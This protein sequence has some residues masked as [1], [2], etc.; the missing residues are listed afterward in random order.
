MKIF[1]LLDTQYNNF[2]EKA[3]NYLSK[4]LSNY[5]AN[6]GNSTIFGQ[7]INVLAGAIQ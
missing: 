4:T 3:K 7:L 2:I 6:Y 5:D 1:S